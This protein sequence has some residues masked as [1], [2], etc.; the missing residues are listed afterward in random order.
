MTRQKESPLLQ[1]GRG[2]SRDAAETVLASLGIGAV[3]VAAWPLFAMILDDVPLDPLALVAHISGMLAGYGV[4]LMLILMSRWPV[5]ER[6]IGADTLARWHAIGGRTVLTLVLTHAV[7]AVL[8]W[9]LLTGQDPISALAQV[10]TWPGLFTATVGTVLMCVVAFA[11]ARSARQRL[12]W[13]TWHS[14]HLTM[15]LAVALGFSHQLAGPDLAGQ[16][17]LQVPWS[18]LYTFTF[19]LVL[20]YRFITPMRSAL[21]HRLRVIAVIPETHSVVSIVIQGRHL[22]ELDAQ[23]GQ[24]FR[25]RF[26]TP[27]SWTTAHPFSISAPLVGNR[28]RLTVKALGDGSER[29]QQVAVG[30]RVIAEGPY[31]AMTVHRRT[32]RDVL[33]IA[34]GVGITPMRALFESIPTDDDQD[35]MLLYRAKTRD[36]I[37]FRAELDALAA[38]RQARVVYLLGSDPGLLST[39]SLNRLVPRLSERD[40]YLCGPPGMAAAVRRALRQAGVPPTQLHEERFAI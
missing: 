7:F 21:R 29:L 32:R 17:W 19:A 8:A 3:L 37:V 5:L 35:L 10:L 39:R 1:S 27:G 34:G 16:P 11:S 22:A 36:Q 38:R 18:M 26:L 28:L 33:L 15:Y 31:G 12:A 30:T 4:L 40:V 14:L 20:H 9:S 25:W 24:F 6:G 13:E 23:P 2:Y